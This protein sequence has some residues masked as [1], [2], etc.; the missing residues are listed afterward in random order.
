M[1]CI[2]VSGEDEHT[3]AGETEFGCTHD[4]LTISRTETG[5][6][7]EAEQEGETER[8]V[9]GGEGVE[10]EVEG[11][12]REAR[13]AAQLFF[14]LLAVFNWGAMGGD[15]AAGE[16]EFCCTQGVSFAPLASETA[17][18]EERREGRGVMGVRMRMVKWGRLGVGVRGVEDE[19]E[20]G[21]GDGGVRVVGEEGSVMRLVAAVVA[22]YKA[23]IR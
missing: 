21:R 18:P 11:E 22:L 13:W 12:V 2:L 16:A 10:G 14:P 20:V 23:M 5:R 3:A 19:V 7:G 1:S 4:V 9:D 17:E 8:V 15:N 6:G